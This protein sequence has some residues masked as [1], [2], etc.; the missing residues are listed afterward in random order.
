M[1]AGMS[2]LF[3]AALPLRRGWLHPTFVRDDKLHGMADLW[4]SGAQDRTLEIGRT[5][6]AL[7]RLRLLFLP[8]VA[9]TTF[10][11]WY[12]TGGSR[13]RLLLICAFFTLVIL[14]L[15]FL[16]RQRR[17]GVQTRTMSFAGTVIA[18]L[19]AS[20][21]GGLDSPFIIVLPVTATTAA[22]AGPRRDAWAAAAVLVAGLPL[23]ALAGG[24]RPVFTGAMI[25]LGVAVCMYVGFILRTMF[26]RMLDRIERAHDDIL[27]MHGEQMQSLTALS[28][29]IAGKLR[30]P[31]ASIRGL[32]VLALQEIEDPA[33]AADR[34]EDLRSEASRMQKLLEQFLNFS[35]PLSP[36][37]LDTVDGV[38]IGGEIVDLFQGVAQERKISIALS[39]TPVELRCDRRKIKQVLINLVQN[40]VEASPPG[41]EIGIEVVSRSEQAAIRVL[42][43][44]HGLA[45]DLAQQVFRPGVT[46]KPRGS[47]LGLT[48]AR[49][50]AQQHGGSLTL[51][52]REGGGCMAELMIPRAQA[53]AAL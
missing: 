17:R 14:H 46:T 1:N 2:A 22:L 34:L 48:I 9:G 30:M 19:L 4:A 6:G 18:L 15:V 35:R 44:G 24:E 16:F 33:R 10:W 32:T 49:S 26:E 41:A 7:L 43:R 12:A 52:G 28:A 29:E 20:F 40:A 45:A 51:I 53:R 42:D 21:T 36:L 13:T 27:R 38:R 39:G 31:L 5:T 47:G 8:V 37:S 25:I 23:L 3:E 11:Y 50:I